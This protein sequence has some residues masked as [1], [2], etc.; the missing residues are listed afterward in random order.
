MPA[1]AK[2]KSNKS[3]K[4]SQASPKKAAS[5]QKTVT[6]SKPAKKV[7]DSICPVCKEIVKDPSADNESG[8]HDAVLCEGLCN[9]WLYRWCAGLS[10]SRFLV[11][12]SSPDPFQCPHCCLNSQAVEIDNLKKALINL[13]QRVSDL[14]KHQQN[15]LDQSDSSQCLNPD[16]PLPG[17]ISPTPTN[18]EGAAPRHVGKEPPK[19]SSLA[20]RNNARLSIVI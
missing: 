20:Q 15:T 7:N 11:I 13:T 14:E 1:A 16:W 19:P 10:K 9:T 8:G 6:S 18:N 2:S 5:K 17:Q 12:S 3:S 4:K